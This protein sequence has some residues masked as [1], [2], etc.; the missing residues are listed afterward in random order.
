MRDDA[1]NTIGTL[2]FA[3][4]GQD[5]DP[6]LAGDGNSLFFVS[7]LP[8]ALVI[9]PEAAGGNYIQFTIGSQSW[10]TSMVEGSARC[11]TGGW[12]STY[13]PSVSFN[14]ASPHLLD[15]TD[16]VTRTETWIAFSF[17]ESGYLALL[18][19]MGID[20]I[21]FFYVFGTWLGV[22]SG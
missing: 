16:D 18:R 7:K 1:G 11:K 12:S 22:M 17:A 10:M 20:E 6:Q 8:D 13:S 15:S 2:G 14:C 4:N 9:T 19:L 5:G 3:P 21:Y